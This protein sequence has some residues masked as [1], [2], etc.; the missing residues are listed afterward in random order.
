MLGKKR[1]H[2]AELEN[3]TLK[4]K[5]EQQEQKIITQ[6]RQLVERSDIIQRQEAMLRQDSGRKRKQMEFFSQSIDPDDPDVN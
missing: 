1:C 5:I 2:A 6:S 4:G 3:E